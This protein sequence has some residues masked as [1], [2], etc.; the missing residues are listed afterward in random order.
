MKRFLTVALL[1]CTIL[2]SFSACKKGSDNARHIPKEATAVV[3]I[4][5]ASIGKKLAMDML[6]G[7]DVFKE[8]SKGA[9]KDSS[10]MQDIQ[11]AGIDFLNTFYMYVVSDKRYSG[12]QKMVGLVPLSDDGKWEAYVKKTAPKAEIKTVDKRKECV[13][14][15]GMYA[16]WDENLLVITNAI[17]IQSEMPFDENGNYIAPQVDLAQTAAE[18]ANLFKMTKENSI[19]ANNK[20]ADM[21]KEG[22][23]VSI[24]VNYESVMNNYG[25]GMMGGFTPSNAMMKDAIMVS[26]LNFD[27]GAINAEMK[28]YVSDEMKGVI[29]KFADTKA[30]K[31][32]V[33]RLPGNNLSA[34]AA[35]S[36]PS[37]AMMEML[38]KFGLLGLVNTG[39]AEAGTNMTAEEVFSAFTGD[40]G[41]AMNNFRIEQKKTEYTHFNDAGE[42]VTDSFTSSRPNMEWVYV[43]KID[44]Q[45]KF[46]KVLQ[47]AAANNVI[48]STGA[49]TYA[50]AG[51]EDAPQIVVKDKYLVVANNAANANAYIAGSNKGQKMHEVASKEI[52]SHPM[53][54]FFDIKQMLNAGAAA[55]GDD[56]DDAA[57]MAELQ[58]TFDNVIFYGGEFK[59]DAYTY[60]ASLN[61]VNKNENSLMQLINLGSKMS[62]IEKREDA[63]VAR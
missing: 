10:A 46:D 9:G 11:N 29:K 4:D 17:T 51:G 50:V 34:V 61:F 37:K 30:D 28:Y 48:T 55:M 26:S 22:N 5:M 62:E 45:D 21:E 31:E 24:W 16:A 44:K 12:D 19:A 42:M 54:M 27:K 32:L 8:M 20:F 25:R 39:L 23:D 1:L 18:M 2:F 3:R 6:F 38:E 15:D 35:L 58:K 40:M 53:T 59:S 60:K 56:A 13:L 49:G 7:S 43:L 36:V 63:V 47:Y 33:E 14:S 52:Y 41:F 57:R